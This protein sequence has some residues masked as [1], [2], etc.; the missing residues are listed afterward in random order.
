MS[1]RRAWVAGAAAAMVL[2][3]IAGYFLA[4]HPKIAEA[5]DLRAQRVS[6]EQAN[7]QLSLD[8]AQL[9]SEF[10]SLP[11]KQAE[12]AV[13]QQQLPS[14]PNLPTMIRSLTGIGNEAGVTVV[15][16]SPST[17]SA[18]AG[19]VTGLFAIPVTVVVQ[20]DFASS[21][22][23]IQKLQTEVRRAFLVTAIG[24][25]KASGTPGSSTPPANGTV[26][27]TVTGDIFVLQPNAVATTGTAVTAAGTTAGTTAAHP[28]N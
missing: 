18:S 10:A 12:L 9:K 3:I 19:N 21:E 8:I 27:L 23:F 20:G 13:I 16:I 6:Q 4:I 28:A 14:A 5:S 22:L 15:S 1:Q 7:N 17:P 24:V 11:A 26:A 25:T 2:L